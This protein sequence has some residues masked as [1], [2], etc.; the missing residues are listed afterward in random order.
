MMKIKKDIQ[1]FLN[2]NGFSI[3]YVKDN[4]KISDSSVELYNTYKIS[5][6]LSDGLVAVVNNQILNVNKGSVLFFRP[7]EVHF[8]RFLRSGTH[9]YLDFYI[10]LSF[11]DC[12]Y[13]SDK[14]LNFLNDK[15]E[16]R[17]N[18]V[19]LNYN[20]ENK[21]F[22]TVRKVIQLLKED[23]DINNIKLFSL[24]LQIVLMCA[25]NYT[26]IPISADNYIPSYVSKSLL[27]ISEHFSEKILLT[28]ISEEIGCSVTY[29]S[30]VFKAYTG[31]TIY[32]HITD[33]RI[34]NA[35]SMLNNGATV[36]EAC[37]SSGFEDC[38]NFIRT[39]KK[40]TGTT[41]KQYKKLACVQLT[42]NY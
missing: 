21:L 37:F 39:F 42:G 16:K 5:I 11:F 17:I 41:P 25:E 22:E 13:E 15:S 30:Q 24:M 34:S 4:Y 23:D 31:V 38:S 36:T 40:I 29:I 28:D 1:N 2:C 32:K 9:E 35:Q 27:Y 7:D 18:Y 33:V 20:E 26:Q 12:F 6:L 10:P 8:G 3:K 14:I 19:K